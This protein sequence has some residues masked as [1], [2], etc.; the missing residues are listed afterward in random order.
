MH[1]ILG[2]NINVNG[3]ESLRDF[4]INVDALNSLS[5]TG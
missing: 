3:K 2:Q 4:P 1:V 5:E